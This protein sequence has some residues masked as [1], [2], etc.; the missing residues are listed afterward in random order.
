MFASQPPQS[1]DSYKQILLFHNV[2]QFLDHILIM[3]IQRLLFF[4]SAHKK[5][6]RSILLAFTFSEFICVWLESSRYLEVFFLAVIS[7]L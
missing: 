7:L 4:L 6:E 1:M 2:I 3:N 5:M